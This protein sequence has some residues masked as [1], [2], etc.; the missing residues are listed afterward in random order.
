MKIV[1]SWDDQAKFHVPKSPLR[2]KIIGYLVDLSVLSICRSSSTFGP[3]TSTRLIAG[4]SGCAVCS[5]LAREPGATESGR[6]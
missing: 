6:E 4:I 2:S 1:R 5:N 3:S